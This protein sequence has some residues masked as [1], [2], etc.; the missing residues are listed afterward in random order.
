MLHLRSGILAPRT[1]TP[2][3]WSW[4]KVRRPLPRRKRN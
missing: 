4:V 3:S 1:K 2:F